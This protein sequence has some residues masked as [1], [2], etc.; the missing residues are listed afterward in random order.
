LPR[1]ICPTVAGVRSV[2]KFMVEL[3]LNPKAAEFKVEDVVD[4]TLCK[5]LGGDGL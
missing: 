1:S 5:R 2:M 3:G 4:L